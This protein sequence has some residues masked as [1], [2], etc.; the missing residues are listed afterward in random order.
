MFVRALYRQEQYDASL[1]EAQQAFGQARGASTLSPTA[2]LLATPP[3]Q[4]AYSPY[5]I[6]VP[7]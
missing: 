4:Q 2:G 1:L 7:H 5:G 6:G 3:G